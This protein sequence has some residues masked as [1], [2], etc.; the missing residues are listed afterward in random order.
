MHDKEGPK[1]DEVIMKHNHL[2]I[3]QP[4]GLNLHITAHGDL[5]TVHFV[6]PMDVYEYFFKDETPS[7]DQKWACYNK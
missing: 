3:Y 6:I 4:Y 7:R 2:R 1:S 5:T